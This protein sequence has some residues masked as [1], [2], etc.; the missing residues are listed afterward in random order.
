MRPVAP[1]GAAA[2]GWAAVSE[3]GG[4]PASSVT[5]PSLRLDAD[6]LHDLAVAL[7]VRLHAL[8]E[9]RRRHADRLGAADHGEALLHVRKLEHVHGHRVEL[10]DHALRRALGHEET[11]PDGRIHAG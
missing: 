4:A 8:V 3:G 10:V 2:T 6:L 5:R 11:H 9:L 7:G 1:A